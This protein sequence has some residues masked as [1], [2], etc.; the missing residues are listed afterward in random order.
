[1]R[2]SVRWR[3]SHQVIILQFECMFSLFR[4]CSPNSSHIKGKWKWKMRNLT[5]HW[6]WRIAWVFHIFPPNPNRIWMSLFIIDL[7]FSFFFDCCHFVMFSCHCLLLSFSFFNLML[8]SAEE[9]VGDL[10]SENAG[11]LGLWQ[12]CQRDET[13]DN[14]QKQLSDFLSIPSIPF[15]VIISLLP[16][17][18]CCLIAIDF[19]SILNTYL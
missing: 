12:V 11:R 8:R 16:F 10:D 13:S 7:P 3:F 19:Y 15:Q 5:I 14:C 4:R 9:W 1:M 6:H 17:Y 2:S 18:T